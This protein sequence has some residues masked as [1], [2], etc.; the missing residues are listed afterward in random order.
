MAEHNF[1][2]MNTNYLNYFLLMVLL[3]ITIGF[4]SIHYKRIND[5]NWRIGGSNPKNFMVN[6]AQVDFFHN[7]EWISGAL[8][9]PGGNN[10]WEEING[11]IMGSDYLLSVLDSITTKWVC[12]TDKILYQG[13]YKLPREK[14]QCRAYHFNDDRF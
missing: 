5:F 8:L 3:L 14:I 11:M 13:S 4:R 12:D 10:G 7:N 1:K 2:Y 9:C 6:Q